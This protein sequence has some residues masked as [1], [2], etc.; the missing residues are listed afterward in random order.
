VGTKFKQED[1]EVRS[2][3]PVE[4]ELV[5]K[6]E[7]VCVGWASNGYVH[8]RRRL[9]VPFSIL[10]AFNRYIRVAHDQMELSSRKTVE[11]VEQVRTNP[12]GLKPENLRTPS[13]QMLAV[14]SEDIDEDT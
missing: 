11:M 10:A 13:T 12:G 2:V 6:G 7:V 8:V 5:Y 1:W 4:I 3:E 14:T 9:V